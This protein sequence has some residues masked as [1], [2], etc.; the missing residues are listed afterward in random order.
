MALQIIELKE[1]E[2]LRS[3][4]EIIRFHAQG[5]MSKVYLA[6]DLVKPTLQWAVKVTH[7]SHP[8]FKR[9]VQEAKILSELDYPAIP[10][11]ADFFTSNDGQLFY[12]VQEFLDG[13]T[14]LS[15][16]KEEPL[17]FA[18]LLDFSVQIC[19]C[20][21]YL[22]NMKPE[23]IVYR[24]L[25]PGNIIVNENNQIKLVDFGIARKFREEQL[26][27]TVKIGTVGFAAPEQ[28]ERKQTDQR[29]DI[30]SLGA[31]L[32]YILSGGKYVYIAQKPIENFCP[33]LPKEFVNCLNKMVQLNPE[34]RPNSINDVKL[35]FLEIAEQREKNE[36]IIIRKHEGKEEEM[37]SGQ[38][39]SLSFEENGKPDIPEQLISDIKAGT[40]K[41]Q[42]AKPEMIG[43]GKHKHQKSS[44]ILLSIVLVSAI[45][46]VALLFIDF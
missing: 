46:Y 1:K 36:A 38:I 7:T 14:L 28:F 15:F 44:L 40:A 35:C 31:M 42:S 13:R 33:D 41:K 30:F 3:R 32:Y 2:I 21:A 18:K 10:K 26:H 16:I 9:I 27:D 43:K 37:I 12:L 45:I 22:H 29:T 39:S 11:I 25:K 4:Y 20:L 23:P 17:S 34:Q 8:L 6:R 24:D 5:G 19:D